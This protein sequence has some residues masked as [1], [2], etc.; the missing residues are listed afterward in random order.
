MLAVRSTFRRA[1]TDQRSLAPP[2]ET[3]AVLRALAARLT[4]ANGSEGDPRGTI[5][6]IHRSS[7]QGKHSPRLTDAL[8]HVLSA[9][10]E[11]QAGTGNAGP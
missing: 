5:R 11:S 1:P 6:P 2:G 8:E 9:V 4:A 3:S 10:F 7:S